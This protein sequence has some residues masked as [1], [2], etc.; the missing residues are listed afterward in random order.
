[1]RT[2]L[3]WSALSFLCIAACGHADDPRERWLDS[4]DTARAEAQKSGKPIFL[5][6]R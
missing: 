3:M 4:F 2:K 5:V 6:F 1:M